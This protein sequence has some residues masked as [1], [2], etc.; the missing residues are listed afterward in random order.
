[1]SEFHASR[2]RGKFLTHVARGDAT[3]ALESLAKEIQTCRRKGYV[4]TTELSGILHEV[5]SAGVE[6]F[7]A[8]RSYEERRR[9]FA[10]LSER[11]S[12]LLAER[13]D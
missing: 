13:S 2:L 1:M 11:V 12:L 7:S 8:W 10:K 3:V 4:S 5:R 9:R 6:E